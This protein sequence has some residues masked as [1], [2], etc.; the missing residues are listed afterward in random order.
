MTH[1]NMAAQEWDNPE[2][3]ESAKFIAKKVI[4]KL[5]LQPEKSLD[6]LDFG[7]GTGLL[8]LNF[9]NHAKSLTGIDT[10]EEMLKIFQKKV[11]EL[12][13]VNI[14]NVDLEKNVT[15][16]KFDLIVSAMAFH[17]LERP[18]NMIKKFKSMLNSKGK[19]AIID[20]ETEDGT[21]HPDNLKMGVKHFGFSKSSIQEWAGNEID[22]SIIN[23]IKKNGKVYPQFL[24]I[25][26]N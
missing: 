22:F 21:F 1:F 11:N 25:I 12:N 13:N 18:D 3:I 14:L 6:V 4:S 2:K 10:S 26:K 9:L 16:L 17:H 8:G 20:L 5:S 15:Q 23:E 7:C 24:A 19:I